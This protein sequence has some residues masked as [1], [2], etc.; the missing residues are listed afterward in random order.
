MNIPNNTKQTGKVFIKK[1]IFFDK[2]IIYSVFFDD[3]TVFP[4]NSYLDLKNV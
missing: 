3:L 1:I 2:K 4:F